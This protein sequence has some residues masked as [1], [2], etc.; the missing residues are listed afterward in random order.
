M[1][2]AG[3]VAIAAWLG[4][5][6]LSPVLGFPRTEPAGM[7]DRFLSPMGGMGWVGWAV[8]LIG[9]VALA[10]VYLAAVKS[11]RFPS[12]IL[13]GLLYGAAVWLI[14]GAVV[15]PIMALGAPAMMADDPMRTSFMMLHLGPL[16]PINA[17]IGR[18]IYGALLGGSSKIR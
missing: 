7:F 15:M 8:L 4:W 3:A 17:L 13:S 12:G 2:S 11:G 16:A 18:L 14:T 1:A 6:A 10:S 9:E 5:L